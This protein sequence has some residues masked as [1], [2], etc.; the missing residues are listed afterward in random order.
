ML[1]VMSEFIL[2]ARSWRL[3]VQRKSPPSGPPRLEASSPTRLSAVGWA[4]LQPALL[5][6]DLRCADG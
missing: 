6:A 2:L 5:G 3:H 4:L 1:S